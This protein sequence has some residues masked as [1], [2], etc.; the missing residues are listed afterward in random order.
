MVCLG[1]ICRSPMAEGVLRHKANLAGKKFE[2][3]SAGTSNFHIGAAPDVRA[4]KKMQKYGIDI[5]DLRAR[6]FQPKDLD[7]FDLVLAMDENNFKDISRHAK[8]PHHKSKVKLILEYAFPGDGMSVPD[9]YY[10]GDSGFENVYSLLERACE[11]I[12]EQH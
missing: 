1:N 3:D 2:I 5:S 8:L 11:K 6:Q 4:I 7:E 10:G 12:I 9:P